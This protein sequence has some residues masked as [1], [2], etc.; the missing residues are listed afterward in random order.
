MTFTVED[1]A[2]LLR[3]LDEHPE[4]REELRRRLLTEG[5]LTLPEREDHHFR[6][7]L[8]ILQELAEAQKRTEDELRVL[9]QRV[10]GLTARLDQLTAR[11][12]D[13]AAQ[14]QA[15]SQRVDDLAAQ[16]QA[17]AVRFE[18]LTGQVQSLT[19]R[20]DRFGARLGVETERQGRAR[21]AEVLHRKGFRL[22]EPILAMARGPLEVDGLARAETPDG[23]RMWVLLEATE[24][25]FPR[26]VRRFIRKLQHPA[27]VAYLRTE[28]PTAEAVL[29]YLYGTTV[30][31]HS[32][33]G[34]QEAGVGVL[35]DPVGEVVEPRP[36]AF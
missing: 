6:Q 20:V 35:T 22:L 11:V 26:N 16:V 15:L 8:L 14:V 3:L 27:L 34:A 23:R 12:D 10:D 9:A 28:D 30:Y 29:P 25:V 32:L 4:W 2:D 33:A 7:I 36:R 18:E 17:L 1:F 13:L 5:L 19:R 21:L 24:R 31:R